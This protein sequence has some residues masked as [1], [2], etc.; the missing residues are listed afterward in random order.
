MMKYLYIKLHV[1]NRPIV[2]LT[3]FTLDFSFYWLSVFAVRF[4][5]LFWD[6]GSLFFMF[7]QKSV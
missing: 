2:F 6:Q 4:T 1:I 7:A 3:R 5:K